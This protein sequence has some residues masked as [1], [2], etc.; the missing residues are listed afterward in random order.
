MPDGVF[1]VL[2][3][4]A[5]AVAGGAVGF[6][7]GRRRDVGTEVRLMHMEAR[8]DAI[9]D[10]AVDGIITIDEQGRLESFNRAA[11]KIFGYRQEEVLGRNI[12][13]LMPE[14]DHSRHDNYLRNY[15]RT[16]QAKII[17]LGREVQGLRKDG[18]TFPMD[19]AVGE[20]R[21]GGRRMFAGT[22]RDISER[23]RTESRLRDSEARNRAI[24][25][26]AVDGVITIDDTGIV[27][28]VNPAAERIFGYRAVEMV[29]RNVKMLMPEPYRSEH[30]G[31]LRNYKETGQ[32]K[33]IG[34]GREV[35]GRRKD[36][37]VFPMDLAV[38]EAAV[39]GGRIFAGFVRDITERKAVDEALRVADERFRALVEG[40]RDYA[41]IMLSPEGRV[42]AW[43]PGAQRLYGWTAEQAEGQPLS[44]FRPPSPE[45]DGPHL[46][47]IARTEGRH[48]EE[49][50]RIRSDGTPFLVHEVITALC[51]DDGRPTG[52]AAVSRDMSETRRHEEDL[53]RARDTAEH[54]REVAESA[55]IEAE[56][57]NMA[58]TKFLAAASHDLRQPV[59]AIFFFASALAHNLRDHPTKPILD[60]L[61]NSLEGLNVL[62]D[63]LLDV[64]RLDAGLVTPKETDFSVN[65]VL[66]RVAA[67]FAPL[68][69]DKGLTLRVARTTAMVRSDPA[70]LARIIQNLV[71]NAV[72]YTTHGSILLGCRR[73][74]GMLS[75]QV[76]DTGIGIPP[77]R[78]KEIF[79]EFTQLGNPER[80]RNQGL[81]L[82]LAIVDR[83][84][85]LLG[86]EITVRSRPG[87]GSVF[88]I[89]V[90]LSSAAAAPHPR[91]RHRSALTENN[92]WVVLIDDEPFVLKGLSMVLQSWGYRVLAATSEAEAMA[93]LQSLGTTPSII[94]ADYR[95]REGR[96]GTEAVAHIRDYFAAS[97]PSIIIT[98]DTA[99]ERLREAEASG[100]SVLH[101]PIQ[102]PELRQ[103]LRDT[104]SRPPGTSVH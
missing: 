85:R 102:P 16:G 26:A 10:A 70:L 47:E 38:G 39:A 40:V 37:A 91:P 51:S 46:L 4:V 12:K 42:I 76:H 6:S 82:G 77:E 3:A 34:L 73:R 83:L 56:R 92:R 59:Q 89:E 24:L 60:D 61:Q 50:T 99:P 72:R 103:A 55:R 43:N 69:R 20:A 104:L 27:R 36:G 88:S 8:T 14:P 86:H 96:T 44:L 95:L 71:A 23:K 2:L 30:D 15:L 81:G 21:I 35:Q 52:F 31:Y 79:E 19:L 49:G 11:E 58:K 13:M 7:L 25:E 67:D 100:F 97:I 87:L 48:E 33:I 64:S 57:A 28:S 78:T 98:G 94:L 41:I 63:S 1:L 74:D 32:A 75:I 29:G 17:G 90:A 18:T 65:S 22:V 54:A 68:A 9:L 53:R 93:Q 5:C 101:K 80:D 62:L 84:A 66:D 45:G